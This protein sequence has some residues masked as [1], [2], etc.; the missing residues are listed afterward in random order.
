MSRST[1]NEHAHIQSS[2]ST[3]CSANPDVQ[4]IQELLQTGR[5]YNTKLQRAIQEINT[6][7]QDNNFVLVLSTP[8]INNN[9][10]PHNNINS[11]TTTPNAPVCLEP[12]E[13]IHGSPNRSQQ[14]NMRMPV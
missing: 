1:I 2:N 4:T 9:I 8:I 5:L 3:A 7:S 13:S 10:T 11:I 12:E 6:V 14:E